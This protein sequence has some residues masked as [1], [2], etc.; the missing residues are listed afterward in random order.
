[1]ASLAGWKCKTLFEELQRVFT[2]VGHSANE[3]EHG[4]TAKDH[5]ALKHS[6]RE[7]RTTDTLVRLGGQ[8][9]AR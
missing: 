9:Y 8:F 7:T 2:G 1:M 6:E 5:P 4:E 3:R